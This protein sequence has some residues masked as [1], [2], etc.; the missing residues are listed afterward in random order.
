VD[1]IFT[2][3]LNFT[4]SL[5]VIITNHPRTEIMKVNDVIIRHST[6]NE[7]IIIAIMM[8]QRKAHLYDDFYI[9]VINH[10]FIFLDM[11]I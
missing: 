7:E 5:K 9:K 3:E 4:I 8:I 11:I 10:F 2:I 6:V 1:E